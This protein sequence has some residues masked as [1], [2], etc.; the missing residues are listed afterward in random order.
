MPGGN[1]RMKRLPVYFALGI[2]DLVSDSVRVPPIEQRQFESQ[3][4]FETAGAVASS[5]GPVL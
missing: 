3:M 2:P 4:A 5:L 1:K